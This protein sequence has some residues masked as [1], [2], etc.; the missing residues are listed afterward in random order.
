V[1][2]KLEKAVDLKRLESELEKGAREEVV[3]KAEEAKA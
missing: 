2:A 1:I 3:A